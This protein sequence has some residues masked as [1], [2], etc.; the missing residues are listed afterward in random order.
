MTTEVLVQNLPSI[1]TVAAGDKLV[2][3][4]TPGTTG[5]VTFSTSVVSDTSPTLGGNLNLGGYSLNSVTATELGYVHGVTSA[6][7][8]QINA[9]AA[10]TAS[11]LTASS[12]TNVVLTLG[13]TPTTALLQATSLTMSWSGTL[14]MARGGSAA[15]LTANTGGI[16]YSGASAMAILAGTAT[17]GLPLIS[18]STAA[19]TWGAV[20]GTGNYVLA[21]SPTLV[22]P[23]L[24]TPTSGTLTSCTGYQIANLAS[25]GSG[26]ATYMTTPTAANLAT[27]IST[28]VTGTGTM[29]FGTSPTLVTPL[30]GTPTSGN[31]SNCTA[32]PAANLSGL[33]TGMLTFLDSGASADLAAAVTDETGTGDLVFNTSPTLVTPILGT[34]TSGTL[35]NCT[36]PTLNQDTSGNAA[37][38]TLAS[39]VTTNANLTGVIT[40]VGNATSIASQ[41]GTGTKFVTQ[42]SPTLITP[43]LGTVAS[44]VISACTS[45]SM[46]MVSP[47][48]GTPTSGTLTNCTGLPIA[49]TTGYGTGVGT[50][51][52]ATPTGSGGI[53]LAISPSFVTPVLG[54]PTSGALTNCTSIPVAQA[55]GNLPVANLNSGTSASSSTYWRGDGTWASP[56]GGGSPGGSNTQVQYNNSSSFGGISGATTNGTTLTLVAPVLGTPASGTLTNCTSIPVAQATGNL[57]VANLNSGTAATS[58]T[59]W[60]GDGTWAS[61]LVSAPT[62]LTSTATAAGTT[63]L[64][65]SSTSIQ[66]FTGT[67]TQ[68]VVLPDVTTLSLTWAFK[69]IN[70]STGSITVNSSGSNLV[71]TV[72]AGTEYTITCILITGT[73]AAS[74]S[75]VAD[76]L[77]GQILSGNKAIVTQSTF[78]NLITLSLPAGLWDVYG[79][80][81]IYEDAG[82][83]SMTGWY[84][85]AST[86]S[87]TPLDPS[88][89]GASALGATSIS[90]AYAGVNIV[91]LQLAITTTTNVY[92]SYFII[93][94]LAVKGAGTIYARRRL[95]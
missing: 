86:T 66:I 41:T 49:G 23:V 83:T 42:T 1:G 24:G 55:T 88:T 27:T 7:Q 45:T 60:R 35:T 28:T 53:A 64:T 79:D 48:L 82:P 89:I 71:Q 57:S 63:T 69:I 52:A 44:G 9:K 40:S 75:A 3:E 72:T 73:S 30:L 87:A 74:W 61:S 56:S 81:V 92:L 95:I 26:V 84:V 18:G 38:A 19:P 6:I 76:L 54:T 80:M 20:T 16:V 36:F 15:N 68:T 14:S 12:D 11:A 32:Y 78:T 50:A 93:T 91:P 4:R 13:G 34:P 47:I 58:S 67:T 65:S 37:T 31:L 70:N 59:Y 5:L 77:I 22:T 21:T 33:A 90:A 51:L 43:A 2:A 25:I 46:T 17:A 29:V 85:W 62:G 8:T 39:T 94:G 10:G